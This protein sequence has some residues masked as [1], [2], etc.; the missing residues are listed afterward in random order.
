MV[1]YFVRFLYVFGQLIQAQQ[2]LLRGIFENRVDCHR[3]AVHETKNIHKVG[4]Y[5]AFSNT[6][7]TDD[8][9]EIWR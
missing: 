1:F 9:K 6:F 3:R 7:E 4:H 8:S 2:A 5:A